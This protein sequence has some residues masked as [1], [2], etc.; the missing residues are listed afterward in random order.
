MRSAVSK[1]GGNASPAG[2]SGRYGE[3][4]TGTKAK[5]GHSQGEPGA[6]TRSPLGGG[7]PTARWNPKGMRR[8]TGPQSKGATPMTNRSAKGGARSS[9]HYGGEGAFIHSPHQGVCGRHGKGS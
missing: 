5:A 6:T 7:V 4:Y 9:P 2:E 8:S 3:A 1:G